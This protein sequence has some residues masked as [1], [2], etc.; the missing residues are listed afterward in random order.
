MSIV[1]APDAP[2]PAPLLAVEHLRVAF[3]SAPGTP[4]AVDDVSFHVEAGE[5]VALVG[6]SGSGKSVTALAVL[7]LLPGGVSLDG[8]VRVDGVELLGLGR[9]RRRRLSPRSIGVVF[10]DPV[11]ALNPVLTVGFQLAEAVRQHDG[12]VSRRT[13]RRRAVELLEL[14][15]IPE[16][17]VRVGYYAHQF[18]GGQCQRIM[19]AMALAGAPDLLVADEPTTALDVTVQAEILDLLRSLR[20]ATGTA[21]LLIT[22]DMGV[23]ADFADRVVVMRH[24]RVV[25]SADVDDLFYAPQEQ[26]TRHLLAAVPRIDIEDRPSAAAPTRSP[27]PVLELT[28]AVV[29]YRRARRGPAFRAVDGVD[30]RVGP[31]EFLGLVGE[32]G[33]GKSTLGRVAVG[34]VPLAAGHVRSVGADL[35]ALRGPRL[36]A[37]RRSTG[38]VFQNPMTSLDPRY[39]VAE[40][41]GESVLV[42]RGLRGRALQARVGELLDAVR[43]PRAFGARRP[44]ELSGGQRQRV[45]IARAIS[46]DPRLLIADEPTSA[47]DVSVQAQVLDLFREL[48]A[49]LGFACLFISHDLAVVDQLCDRVAVLRTGRVVEE[50]QVG[51]VLRRP[52]DPYT[53]RLVAASPLPD[54]RAQRARRAG[55][56]LDPSRKD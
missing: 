55:R 8:S 35:A 29:E 10:Q 7:G 37:H 28:D 12:S 43:L 16:P 48:Q 42:H 15:G 19:I 51:D 49:E 45:S 47:L 40:S 56:P 24:G 34:A 27:D 52:Q 22:H 1:V 21:V 54:P 4:A 30:L 18:S 20:A 41:I 3:T 9:A 6:E 39:T 53:Q 31:G 26:Y 44:H 17:A 33:S 23:V 13:A 5:V 2:A 11:A 36:R 32:S 25:E 50:G 46:L 14:V 38:M